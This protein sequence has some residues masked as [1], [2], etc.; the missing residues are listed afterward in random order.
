MNTGPDASTGRQ[1]QL[2]VVRW[3][4][5][6]ADV[7]TSAAVEVTRDGRLHRKEAHRPVKPVRSGT[8]QGR[9]L[10]LDVPTQHVERRS[11]AGSGKVARGPEV[12]L[13][14]MDRELGELLAQQAAGDAFEA[15]D[16]RRERELRLRI[17]PDER[18]ARARVARAR[19]LQEGAPQEAPAPLT[20]RSSGPRTRSVLS[21]GAGS[22]P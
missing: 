4:S 19:G 18:R 10:L 22:G 13:V 3:V 8:G 16:E 6:G 1:V 17:D 15:V 14:G 2:Q 9:L 11:A 5:D 7:A 20:E 12:S 21:R